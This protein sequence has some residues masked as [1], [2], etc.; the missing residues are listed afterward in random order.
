MANKSKRFL[1]EPPLPGPWVTLDEHYSALL[2]ERLAETAFFQDG[3]E[4]M[5][6]ARVLP[7]RFYPGWLLCDFPI[8]K[9]NEASSDEAEPKTIEPQQGRG[10][11]SFLYG[12]DGFTAL[13]GTSWS[14][15]GHNSLHG[16][17]LSDDADLLAYLRF[18]CFFIRGAEG[19]FEIIDVNNLGCL[20]T[21]NPSGLPSVTIETAKILEGAGA[22]K[23]EAKATIFFGDKLFAAHFK[24]PKS[25]NIA[26]AD[27]EF[28]SG[29]FVRNPRL[30]FVNTLRYLM[31]VS[32][33]GPE[34]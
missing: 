10:A 9:K 17:T 1:L 5:P 6:F 27:D 13:D 8:Q 16:V 18:F 20:K 33:V 26:M 2:I 7:L 14:I 31:D 11:H 29:E 24:I 19:P 21:T 34:K 3:D 15:H 23:A 28:L 25:G 12:P 4:V 30:G 32:E 22:E